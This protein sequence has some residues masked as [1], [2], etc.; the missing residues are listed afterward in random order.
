MNCAELRSKRMEA[1][2]NLPALEEEIK[3]V[4][5]K[6]TVFKWHG[7]NTTQLSEYIEQK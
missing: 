5:R 7:V 3:A 2:K 4:R 1:S 6:K